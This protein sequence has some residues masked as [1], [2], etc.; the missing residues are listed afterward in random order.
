MKEKTKNWIVYTIHLQIFATLTIATIF[1]ELIWIIEGF[2]KVYRYNFQA[3]NTI[4]QPSAREIGYSIFFITFMVMNLTIASFSLY[5]FIFILHI[6]DSNPAKT[7]PMCAFALDFSLINLYLFHFSIYKY[8]YLTYFTP[9]F[10]SSVFY[11]IPNLIAQISEILI[12][13]AIFTVFI[14]FR[15]GIEGIY[16]SRIFETNKI[17]DFIHSF[18]IINGIFTILLIYIYI[19]ANI[20]TINLLG[21]I[22]SLIIGFFLIGLF[23]FILRKKKLRYPIEAIALWRHGKVVTKNGREKR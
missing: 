10:V 5:A 6:L 4:T 12:I 9:N 23:D 19:Y 21:F 7:A 2:L 17:T 20:L 11:H 15:F 3:N 22:F 13:I 14:N 8:K 1:V 18:L 16:K